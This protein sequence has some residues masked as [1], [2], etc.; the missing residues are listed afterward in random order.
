MLLQLG[1][2]ILAKVFRIVGALLVWMQVAVRLYVQVPSFLIGEASVS[3]VGMKVV[4]ACK[5]YRQLQQKHATSAGHAS[6]LASVW[7]IQNGLRVGD[8]IR[9][10][11]NLLCLLMTLVILG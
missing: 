10:L 7:N 8:R 5:R 1:L 6:K 11:A 2:S 3:K 4:R 9:R